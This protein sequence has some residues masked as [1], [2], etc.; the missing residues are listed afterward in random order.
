M[1]FDGSFDVVITQIESNLEI[2]F[3]LLLID[4]FEHGLDDAASRKPNLFFNLLTDIVA[5]LSFDFSDVTLG[6]LG[7]QFPN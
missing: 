6:E 2:F 5:A 4:I 1:I 7:Q 3:G